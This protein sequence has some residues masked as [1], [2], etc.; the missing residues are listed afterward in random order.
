[1]IS[2]PLPLRLAAA[3]EISQ[4]EQDEFALRSHQLARDAFQNGYLEDIIS[5]LVPGNSITDPVKL[6]LVFKRPRDNFKFFSLDKI[7][8]YLEKV[9]KVWH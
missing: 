6:S 8:G 4:Q 7:I 1:M 2:Q 3:F 9:P 5:I